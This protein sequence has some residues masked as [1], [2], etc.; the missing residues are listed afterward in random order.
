MR[1]QLE[2]L[3]LHETRCSN[4]AQRKKVIDMM[5]CLGQKDEAVRLLLETEPENPNY[6]EDNLKACLIAST[7]VAEKNTPHSTTKLVATNL[8]AEGKLWEGVQL[9][10]LIDKVSDACKYLQSCNEWD[11]SLWLAKCR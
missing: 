11:A 10:C 2:R 3:H 1:Y 7:S 6:Y 4:H 5:L 9:L 8:I